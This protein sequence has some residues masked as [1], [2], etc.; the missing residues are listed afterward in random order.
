[1]MDNA[2]LDQAWDMQMR[3]LVR[4]RCGTAFARMGIHTPKDLADAIKEYGLPDGDT[5]T[6]FYAKDAPWI[7]NAG[8]KTWRTALTLLELLGFEWR[9][10]Q[11]N[12]NP[13]RTEFLDRR[14]TIKGQ[15]DALQI[16]LQEF[17]EWYEENVKE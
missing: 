2:Q 8:E 13:Y 15:I 14:A 3:S 16:T 4:G 5:P 9:D 1:M 11:P 12:G 10:Y 17:R 6:Y 7:R